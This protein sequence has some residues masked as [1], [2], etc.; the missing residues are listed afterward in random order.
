[1]KLS[2]HERNRFLTQSQ[3]N[4]FHM[5][6]GKNFTFSTTLKGHGIFLIHPNILQLNSHCLKHALEIFATMY[7]LMFINFLRNC[8]RN[9]VIR[10]F[11]ICLALNRNTLQWS[12]INRFTFTKYIAKISFYSEWQQFVHFSKAIMQRVYLSNT[13]VS[14]GWTTPD[15]IPFVTCSDVVDQSSLSS[16]NRES[17]KMPWKEI[18]RSKI[19]IPS[20]KAMFIAGCIRHFHCCFN[21][22]SHN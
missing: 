21:E 4:Y 12:L 7:I 20:N 10:L 16:S 8:L 22:M 17:S 9:S 15:W 2:N 13:V 14:S 19:D 6:S 3:N 5:G 1:M 18:L 11:C